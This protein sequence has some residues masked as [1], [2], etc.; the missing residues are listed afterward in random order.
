[1][2]DGQS[3][4][5]VQCG[6]LGATAP[7]PGAD[8]EDEA[9]QAAAP[10]SITTPTASSLGNTSWEQ[11][12]IGKRPDHHGGREPGECVLDCGA[13]KLLLGSVHAIEQIMRL[14]RAGVE[15]VDWENRPLFSFGRERVLVDGPPSGL[16]RRCSRDLRIHALD[17]GHGPVLL[18][19]EALRA[20]RATT[21]LRTT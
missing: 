10:T 1:M 12:P 5:E 21:T 19:V 8:D 20:L 18:S 17:Q 3:E 4:P 13:T 7:E 9:T 6:L 16:G 14:S 15:A 11:E 2:V